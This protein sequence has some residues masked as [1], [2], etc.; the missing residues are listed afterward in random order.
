MLTMNDQKKREKKIKKKRDK[1]SD[2]NQYASKMERRR[3]FP[4]VAVASVFEGMEKLANEISDAIK[5][6][7]DSDKIPRELRKNLELMKAGELKVDFNRCSDMSKK[8]G[9]VLYEHMQLS[10]QQLDRITC[11][12]EVLVGIQNHWT[13]TVLV[14][15]LMKIGSRLFCSPKQ[16]QVDINGK[17]RIVAYKY[18]TLEQIGSRVVHDPNDYC[19]R[20]ISFAIPFYTKYFELAELSNGQPCIKLW[21]TCDPLT[22]LG[23]VHGELLGSKACVTIINGIPFF[24]IDRAICYYLLGYCPIHIDESEEKYVLLD[25]LWIPGMDK[26]PEW[27]AFKKK[28]KPDTVGLANF[29]KNVNAHTYFGLVQNRDLQF[30]RELHEFVPQVRVI[31]EPV[32]DYPHLLEEFGPSIPWTQLA[33]LSTEDRNK[34]VK[35]TFGKETRDRPSTIK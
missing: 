13:I 29:S 4:M 9:Q 7:I 34:L 30:I 11:R 2:R 23:P 6:L 12:I 27:A 35:K 15:A 16:Y 25:S 1:L 8:F 18:H 24:T 21:N 33:N 5:V 32:F 19:S 26:T 20:A 3:R 31:N 10:H 14:H 22:F 17:P 28:L